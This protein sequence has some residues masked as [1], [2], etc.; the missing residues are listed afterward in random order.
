MKSSDHPSANSKTVKG[1]KQEK[2]TKLIEALND[3]MREGFTGSIKV[4]IS[5]GSIGRVEKLEE[6][7]E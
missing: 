2:L 1:V 4:N 7:K 5:Q 6:V 3:L